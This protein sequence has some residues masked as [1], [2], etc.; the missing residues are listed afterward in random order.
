MRVNVR[1][2]QTKKAYGTDVVMTFLKVDP[3]HLE[4]RVMSVRCMGA[5]KWMLTKV[6]DLIEKFHLCMKHWKQKTK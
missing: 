5:V 6:H 1:T 2:E 3:G 4:S